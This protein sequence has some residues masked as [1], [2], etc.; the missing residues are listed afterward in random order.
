M[1]EPR[2]DDVERFGVR[3][4]RREGAPGTRREQRG[5]VA[6]QHGVDALDVVGREDDEARAGVGQRVAQR[7]VGEHVVQRH[8][9]RAD[10]PG[11]EQR[12]EVLQAVRRE[13]R[14]A[15]ALADPGRAQVARE[16]G[17]PVGELRVV[18]LDVVEPERDVVGVVAGRATQQGGDVHVLAPLRRNASNPSVA[19]DERSAAAC[20]TASRSSDPRRS[21]PL[22]WLISFFDSATV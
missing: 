17:R 3:Q 16:P 13:H 20:V 5:G 2:H 1:V 18:D 10:L 21:S 14:D 6:L 12:D 11:P 7:R 8:A 9:D 4:R 19:A 15:L 22:E